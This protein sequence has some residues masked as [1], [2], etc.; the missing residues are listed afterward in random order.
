MYQ[1]PG[2]RYLLPEGMPATSQAPNSDGQLDIQLHLVG[3]QR[4]LH[5]VILCK[6]P[7]A[8]E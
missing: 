2:S 7:A 1:Q 8:G 5:K 6:F 3:C 4:K